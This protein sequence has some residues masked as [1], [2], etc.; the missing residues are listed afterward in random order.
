MTAP[1]TTEAPEN[2]EQQAETPQLAHYVDKDRI[3]DALVEGFALMTLCG[4]MLRPGRAD[5]LKLP[6]CPACKNEFEKIHRIF[7]SN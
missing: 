7:N 2:L 5:P 4:I 6:V 1:T 3:V